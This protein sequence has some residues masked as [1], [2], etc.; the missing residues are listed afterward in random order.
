MMKVLMYEMRYVNGRY[1]AV[2]VLSTFILFAI[3]SIQERRSSHHDHM[4]VV[5]MHRV[6]VNTRQFC[7]VAFAVICLKKE[8]NL[9][10]LDMIIHDNPLD[11]LESLIK[12]SELLL[13]LEGAVALDDGLRPLVGVMRAQSMRIRDNISNN[14]D[15]EP[16]K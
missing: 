12:I 13:S 6:C 5:E 10:G 8:I 11:G 15:S 1:L 14:A 4:V 3:R 16:K 2:Y 7:R 9:T